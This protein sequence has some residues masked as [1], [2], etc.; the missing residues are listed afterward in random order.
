MDGGF[1]GLGFVGVDCCFPWD[2]FV[3]VKVYPMVCNLE[4][5]E[6]KRVLFERFLGRAYMKS[7]LMLIFS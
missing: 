7:C 4:K 5:T 3:V 2:I 1:T 6:L